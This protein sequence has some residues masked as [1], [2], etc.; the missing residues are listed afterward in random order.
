VEVVRKFVFP[1]GDFAP[2]EFPLSPTFA[3]FGRETVFETAPVLKIL[4]LSIGKRGNLVEVRLG[5]VDPGAQPFQTGNGIRDQFFKMQDQVSPLAPRANVVSPSTEMTSARRLDRGLSVHAKIGIRIE[6]LFPVMRQR[7]DAIPSVT[8][9]IH[10]GNRR[11]GRLEL[12]RKQV[13]FHDRVIHIL[14][15]DGIVRFV[16]EGTRRKAV[17]FKKYVTK[18]RVSRSR[19]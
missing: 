1:P 16:V 3:V 2:A 10:R 18:K 19:I 6:K 12:R 13:G 17:G 4:G 9:E 15:I 8:H 11:I 7:D 5:K 14:R